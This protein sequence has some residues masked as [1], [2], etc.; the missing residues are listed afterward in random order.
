MDH[1]TVRTTLRIGY[2]TPTPLRPAVRPVKISETW[3]I[4]EAFFD[5][6]STP[7]ETP[8]L[9]VDDYV[10]SQFSAT[11]D[12]MEN[13]LLTVDPSTTGVNNLL[14]PRHFHFESHKTHPADWN[15]ET[16]I[17][18][19]NKFSEGKSSGFLFQGVF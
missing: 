18:D 6:G 16:A 9:L 10:P 1:S 19:S 3:L 11:I 15:A 14:N 7:P 8:G 13:K 4:L 2:S 17:R 12:A 5:G